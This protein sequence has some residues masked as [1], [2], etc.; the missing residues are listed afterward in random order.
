MEEEWFIKSILKERMYER[1]KKER[2]MSMI[3][4][5]VSFVVMKTRNLP[6]VL[7]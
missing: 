3:H 1:K 4:Y 6:K 5:R 2:I 7:Y